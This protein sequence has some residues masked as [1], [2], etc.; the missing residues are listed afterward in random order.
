MPPGRKPKSAEQRRAEG[1][2]GKR[3]LPEP[4]IV[5]GRPDAMAMPEHLPPAAAEAWD[6]IVPTLGR[7]GILDGVDKPALEAMCTQYARARQAGKVVAAQGHLARGS[8]GQIR[9]HPSL[10]TERA[11]HAM[12]L[13]FAEHYALTPVSRVRLGLAELHRRSLAEEMAEALGAT[14]L[15]PV[16]G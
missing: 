9:E 13:R 12:F 10:G 5:A 2:P 16:E 6:E 3:P 8:A 15:E 11:A 1:N 4:V 14:E 7:L